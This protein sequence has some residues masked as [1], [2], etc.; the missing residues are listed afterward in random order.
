MTSELPPR[1]QEIVE[2]WETAI[3]KI[4]KANEA[5]FYANHLPPSPIAWGLSVG[6]SWGSS[7]R[8][9]YSIIHRE[10]SN[11]VLELLPSLV[12]EAVDRLQ[13]EAEQ[14]LNEARQATAKFDQ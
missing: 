6:W 7:S 14:T 2:T 1:Y 3:S 9:G 13:A 5:R 8:D 10:V 4:R 11:R 12:A